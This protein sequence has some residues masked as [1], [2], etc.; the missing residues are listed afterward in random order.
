M[1]KEI[2]QMIDK[3]KSFNQFINESLTADDYI[4]QLNSNEYLKLTKKLFNDIEDEGWLEQLEEFYNKK[5][6]VNNFKYMMLKLTDNDKQGL[7]NF[8][9]DTIEK[10][11]DFDIKLK[12]MD[13][14][15]Y[16]KLDLIDYDNGI[17]FIVKLDV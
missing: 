2:R 10:F 5:F 14:Y 15:P 9:D 11:N 16:N 8:D 12:S 3:I 17:V 7:I 1:S 4:N 13:K 6:D